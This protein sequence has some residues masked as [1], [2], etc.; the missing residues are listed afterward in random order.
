MGINSPEHCSECDKDGAWSGSPHHCTPLHC[1]Y[2]PKLENGDQKLLNSSTV[3]F[4]MVAYSCVDS[5]ILNTTADKSTVT[6]SVSP[7]LML[8]ILQIFTSCH[9]VLRMDSGHQSR[10]AVC[11]TPPPWCSLTGPPSPSASSASSS[12][13]SS[14]SSAGPRV[15]QPA[16]LL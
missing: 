16:N 14:S 7:S 15:I 4:S 6:M 11:L 9:S 8:T 5:Y 12:S 1:G 2:P 10:S 3:L 13:S